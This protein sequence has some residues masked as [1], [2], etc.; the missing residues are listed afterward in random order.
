MTPELK[1]FILAASVKIMIV[2]GLVN[3]GVIMVIWAER[4]FSAFLQDRLGPNRCGPQ[5]L[6]PS[7]ADGIKNF[8]KEDPSILN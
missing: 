3:L 4:R 8:T 7:L 5:G 1:G 2:F 6:V